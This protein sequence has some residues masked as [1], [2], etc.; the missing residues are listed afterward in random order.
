MK[1]ILAIAVI[2]LVALAGVNA[3]KSHKHDGMTRVMASSKTLVTAEPN[4]HRF[5]IPIGKKAIGVPKSV[6]LH[7]PR[8]TQGFT[9][10]LDTDV[11]TLL[12]SPASSDD[13]HCKR[14]S[15]LFL[16]QDFHDKTSFS[17]ARSE[18]VKSGAISGYIVGNK[19]S[20]ISVRLTGMSFQDVNGAED[21]CRSILGVPSESAHNHHDNDN[22]NDGS[23]R[24]P[25]NAFMVFRKT[26]KIVGFSLL[27]LIIVWV[28][29]KVLKRCCC[30]CRRKSTPEQNI[31]MGPAAVEMD[32]SRDLALAIERSLADEQRVVEVPQSAA[33]QFIFLP[34]QFMPSPVDV[35]HAGATPYVPM[36]APQF[37]NYSLEER[38]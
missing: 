9:I 2:A 11:T 34:P 24:R 14:V 6:S 27:G 1:L 35:A 5:C 7:V 23:H 13:K 30:C 12:S 22:D 36:F 28:V 37:M 31:E 4:M 38:K 21:V 15:S 29:C 8:T 25:H 17:Y 19:P 32:E 10:K 33:P 18:I 16:V 20:W 3:N 26:L